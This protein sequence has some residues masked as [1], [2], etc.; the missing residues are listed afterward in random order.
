MFCTN[1]GTEFEG[2]FCPNCGTKTGEQPSAQTVAPKETHEYYG[3]EGDLI[4]LSTIYGVYKDRT[5][6]AAFFRKCTDYDSVAIGKALDYIEDNVKPKEYGMLDTIRMKRQIEAPIEKIIRV[7]AVNDPS[8]K[9]QKAQLSELKKAN[10]LQQK[11]MNAQARCPRCGSTSLSAHKKG[12]GIGKAVIGAAVT[13]PLGLGLIGAV[14]GNKGA[15]KVRVTC[16]KCGKQFW[17]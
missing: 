7:Q 17:A 6:M 9:L 13:A 12:F 3:K 1:C 16:L 2:N 14:A 4:D 10:K 15:K 5:N 8:V 11:E